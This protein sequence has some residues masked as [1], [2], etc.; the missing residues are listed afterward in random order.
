[1]TALSD[2]LSSA[3]PRR[4]PPSFIWLIGILV[5]ALM[6]IPLIYLLIRAGQAD[7]DAWRDLTR[8]S[9]LRLLRNTVLM[10]LAVAGGSFRVEMEAL[11]R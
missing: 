6:A 5:A 8:S 2:Q 4:S 11:G 9:T 1:M 10:A 7:A 3:W